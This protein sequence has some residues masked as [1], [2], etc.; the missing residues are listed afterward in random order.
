MGPRLAMVRTTLTF[1]IAL[2][3]FTKGWSIG[4]PACPLCTMVNSI[5]AVFDV[6]AC[7]TG[8]A[9]NA[10]NET[11]GTEPAEGAGD[12]AGKGKGKGKGTGGGEEK[13]TLYETRS[14]P[15]SWMQGATSVAA[16]AAVAIS[17][18]TA[19]IVFWR[20]TPA[21]RANVNENDELLD[22]AVE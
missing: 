1:G 9:T 5:S 7:G 6:S 20:R 11:E 4:C 18:T 2:V 22:S 16:G 21:A 8:N 10:T 19:L 13:A 17:V 14:T 3:L 12:G 15:T